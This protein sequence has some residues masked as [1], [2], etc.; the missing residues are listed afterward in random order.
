MAGKLDGKRIAFL[1]T[2][3]F[4]QIEHTEPWKAVKQAGGTPVLVS[5]KSDEVQG[6][7]GWETADT[8]KVDASIEEAKVSEFDGLLLPGGVINGDL[9]RQCEPAVRFVR[10]MFQ[11]GKPIG[12]ICHGPWALVEADVVRGLTL[13][14]YPTLQTDI[15]N[16][17]GTWVDDECRTSAGVV[18]SRKP[19]DLPTFCTK[20]VEEFCEGDHSNRRSSLLTG[21]A[22]VGG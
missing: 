16:A 8:F 9:L 14:S 1:M 2:D 7:N 6:F 19:D 22:N 13:T 21:T 12:A 5:D 15:R 18:T 10:E 11:A 4:E 17:G 3:G 20:I